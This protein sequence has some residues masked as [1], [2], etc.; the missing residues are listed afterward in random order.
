MCSV[1]KSLG[2][3]ALRRTKESAG[4][5]LSWINHPCLLP[6]MLNMQSD[7]ICWY[8][9]VATLICE[10]CWITPSHL[11]DTVWS[12]TYPPV[13]HL[14]CFTFNVCALKMA[15]FYCTLQILAGHEGPVTSLAFSSSKAIL[16]SGSWDKTVR[17]WDI[18]EGKATKEVITLTSDG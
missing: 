2:Q 9:L 1:A 14:V 8:I 10:L 7:K 6:N 15:R 13:I 4:Q 5:K 12:Y 3:T 16:A 11:T 17:L 18:F